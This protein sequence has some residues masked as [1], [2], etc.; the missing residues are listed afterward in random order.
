M[1]LTQSLK[2][3]FRLILA[4]GLHSAAII[5]F[6]ISLMKLISIAQW[7]HFAY[8]IISIAMLGFGA[9]GTLLA[10]ARKRLVEESDWLVPFLM[11]LSGLFMVLVFPI[12]RSG[13]FRF[14]VFKLFAGG[15]GFMALLLNYLLYF[16][17]FFTGA[18]AIGI[19]F[20][21]KSNQI[22]SYYFGNLLGS[23]IGGILSLSLV[24]QVTPVQVPTLVG[25]LPVLS[26]LMIVGQGQFKRIIPITMLALFS[27]GFLLIRPGT[28]HPSE[29]KN[30]QLARQLPEAEVVITR[31]SIYG[32]VEVV[33]SPA[34]RFSPALSLTFSNSLPVGKAVFVNGDYYGHILNHE[35]APGSHILNYTTKGLP[36]FLGHRSRVLSVNAGSGTL[37]SQALH[38]GASRVDATI[39]NRAIV[40]MMK[41][42][43]KEASGGI[44]LSPKVNV[45]HVHTRNFLANP[46][47]GLFD[48]II[49]PFL[50]EF[51]GGAGLNALR[52]EYGYT[53]EAFDKMIN[54]LMP[55]GV[56]A[57]STWKDQPPRHSLKIA[58]TLTQAALNAGFEVPS[59]HIVAVRSWGT[60]TFL[61]KNLPFTTTELERVREFCKIMHF[62]P[63]LLPGI[64]PHERNLFNE[65]E[66]LV[67][68]QML[69]DLLASNPKG[70][71][72]YEFKIE[73]ATDNKPYFSHFM[74]LG[75]IGELVRDFGIEQF[76]F[77]ELGFLTLLV[78]LGQ[79]LLLAIFLI[80]LPLF[81]L[82]RSTHNKKATL[83]YFGA[84]GLGYMFAEIILI[85]RFV[86]YLG[87]PI[88]AVVAV[89]STMMV[90]SGMGSLLSQRI[91][92]KK[93]NIRYIGGGVSVIMLILLLVLTP[94]LEATLALDS[95][96]KIAISLLAIGIPAFIMGMMF[97]LGIRYL[98]GHDA[99]QIPWAWGING[100]FSVISTS[101]VTLIS[102]NAG[103]S[104]VILIAAVAYLV[105][106]LAFMINRQH[107][108]R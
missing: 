86:L 45:H 54:R 27:A 85:Q 67:F 19:V 77:L 12:S 82:K 66:G 52:E 69:D 58:A 39:E 50:S 43:L 92:P 35:T 72:N 73:P 89:I 49:L 22:G 2:P 20:I 34:Q 94:I 17:P 46:D 8:M 18:L 23:G 106:S 97:P 79:S 33:H 25:L 10:L 21:K 13:M 24:A 36:Y 90:F 98:Q 88:Y 15:G 100:C 104:V 68:F 44:F 41:N 32:L 3:D 48:L 108:A 65:M 1:S 80:I 57:I 60:I 38:N 29:Y 101:L 107:P 64:K 63:L 47:A 28:I 105:A 5:A 83:L 61:L 99:S 31:P 42:E 62:D 26:G 59:D 87:Q 74:R 91:E 70:T 51:G 78:T 71:Y 30:I 9:S 7:H 56:I 75:R 96:I 11:I 95:W 4:I 14:D 103:F 16:L 40:S 76:P 55:G 37:I 84:L 102:L 81:T 93:A 6:Q 53:L